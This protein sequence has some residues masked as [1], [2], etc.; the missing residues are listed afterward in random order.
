MMVSTEHSLLSV[1]EH[2]P[3]LFTTDKHLLVVDDKAFE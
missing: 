2:N 3:L 1:L